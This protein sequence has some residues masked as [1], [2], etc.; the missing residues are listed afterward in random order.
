[1]VSEK[2]ITRPCGP[3]CPNVPPSAIGSGNVFQE[4][5]HSIP[6]SLN[7]RSTQGGAWNNDAGLKLD[8]AIYRAFMWLLLCW[9]VMLCCGHPAHD[10]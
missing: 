5:A 1:M 2:I 4:T 6:P 7:V 9:F 8:A 3:L 10:W